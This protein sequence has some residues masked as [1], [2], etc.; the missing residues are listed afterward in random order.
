M[1]RGAPLIAIIPV[2]AGSKGI[3]GKNLRKFGGISL[4][5]RTILL[6]KT[7]PRIDRI[8]VSTD[9]PEMHEI[10]KSHNV[11]APALRPAAFAT[12]GAKTVDAVLHELGQIGFAEGHL[13]LLQV[14]SPLRRNLDLRDFLDCYGA[15]DA[16]AMVSV[17]RH[18]EPR[19][20][21]LQKIENGLLLPYLGEQAHEGPRQSL[22]QPYALNGAFYGIA[23]NVLK[24][25]GRFLP[26]GTLPFEM[27]PEQSHNL[28]SQQDAEIL[29]AMLATGKW[30][31]QS[32]D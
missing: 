20:E 28:D 3:P 15:T 29:E 21:K 10:A 24:A 25:Q 27:Q 30:Q 12:D 14:T 17:V 4:L 16:P 32:F 13:V 7:D 2:R 11:S 9:S 18:E 26:S 23:V 31:L 8:L 6:A 1:I 22:P 5:E 19:P